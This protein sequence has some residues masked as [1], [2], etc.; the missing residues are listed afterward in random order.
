MN[1]PPAWDRMGHRVYAALGGWFWLPC[2]RC[3][4][5]FG[6]HESSDRSVPDPD[7][8]G[9]GKIVCKACAAQMDAE[10]TP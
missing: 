7:R 4:V 5:E 6:G 1:Y 9:T 2:P 10:A 8:P 3:G